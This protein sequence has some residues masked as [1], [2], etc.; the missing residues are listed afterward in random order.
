M[1]ERSAVRSL[2]YGRSF[3]AVRTVCQTCDI[4]DK[5]SVTALGIGRECL[6]KMSEGGLAIG[7]GAALSGSPRLAQC[8]NFRRILPRKRR[9]VWLSA[10]VLLCSLSNALSGGGD[11]G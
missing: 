3:R 7:A 8:Q 1:R 10:T 11:E 4:A 9:S 6:I 2:L 5:A